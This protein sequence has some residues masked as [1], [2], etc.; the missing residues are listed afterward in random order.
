MDYVVMFV[1][2]AVTAAWLLRIAVHRA[3]DRIMDRVIADPK[4][5]EK[6]TAD[7]ELKVEFDQETYFTY[8]THNNQFVC[9]AKTVSQLRQRLSEMFPNQTATIVDGDPAVLAVLAKELKD[10]K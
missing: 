7:I 10:I 5:S 1:L 9:Q 3:V 8:N 2:G 4:Q 6:P